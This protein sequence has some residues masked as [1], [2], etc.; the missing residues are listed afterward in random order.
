MSIVIDTL[1][2]LANDNSGSLK[3]VHEKV[4]N[5]HGV[6]LLLAGVRKSLRIRMRDGRRYDISVSSRYVSVDYS[7]RELKLLYGTK[8]ER[9]RAI[10]TLIGE[11]LDEAHAD[12]DVKGRDVV[13][14]GAYIGD[15]PIY[16]A[17]KGARHVY[18]F[19]PYPYS[20]DMARRNVSANYL[21]RKVTMINAG[22]G[23]KK[24]SITIKSDEGNLAGSAMRK[25]ESGKRIRIL[26]LSTIVADYK[27][28][29]AA[30]KI[31]CEGCEYDIVLK[32]DKSTL[33]R[34]A[35]ILIEYH[36]GYP[37]LVRKLKDSGFAIRHV[38]EEHA[39]RNVNVEN[40]EMHGGTIVATLK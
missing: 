30:L 31:D 33:R 11:F 6:L 9:I 7:G 26:P 40:Q 3:L 34:F 29:N 21:N 38:E 4:V 1:S 2:R 20:Y 27:L 24:G 5:W 13:D 17:L 19:E 32:S 18:A 37:K 12:L 22:C 35:S 28:D 8:K 23:S 25:S 36:Y 15:T 39:M 10:L 14:I 16:F